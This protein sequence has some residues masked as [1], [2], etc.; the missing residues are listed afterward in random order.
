MTNSYLITIIISCNSEALSTSGLL[1][2]TFLKTGL[3][4]ST[5]IS[6]QILWVHVMYKNPAIMV[7][8]TIRIILALKQ[9][10]YI[11]CCNIIKKDLINIITTK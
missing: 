8:N 11:E 10:Y 7:H 5:L 4:A 9:M 6:G 3:A 1:Y 2:S